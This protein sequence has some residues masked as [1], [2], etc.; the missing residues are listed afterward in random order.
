MTTPGYPDYTRLSRSGGVELAS[1]TG[2]L[3]NL[4]QIFNGYVGN[5][6]HVAV[7]ILLN[8]STDFTSVD[9]IWYSDN[10]FTQVVGFRRLIRT[11]GQFS[12]TLSVNQSD[13]LRLQV[14]TKSGAAMSF[15]FL[16]I[17]GCQAVGD[18]FMLASM[19]VPLIGQTTSVPAASTVNVVP[20]HVQPGPAFFT[21]Q[22]VAASWFV[23]VN[24]YDWNA[25]AFTLYRQFNS[26][27]YVNNIGETFSCLDTPQQFQI[28]NSDA[29]AKV[30]VVGWFSD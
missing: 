15:Q 7:T 17:Y 25:G 16:S 23:N 29:A 24:Y 21:L 6:S 8:A 28:H 18:Q 12:E 20:A 11:G 26:A 9:L 5:F 19:D 22:T 30:F 10:T 14:E 3:T 2:N 13:W 1:A 4:Q 27:A